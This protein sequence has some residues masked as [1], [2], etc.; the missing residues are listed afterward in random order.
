MRVRLVI[1]LFFVASG[2]V[3]VCPARA[4]EDPAPVAPDPEFA[5]RCGAWRAL[6]IPPGGVPLVARPTPPHSFSSPHFVV[7]YASEAL[8]DYARGVSGFAEHA[9]RILVDTLGHLPP[10][11]DG[12]AGGDERIDVYVRTP[13]ELGGAYG[14]TVP[15]TQVRQPYL[16]SY[17][18]WIEIVDTMTV[19]H[20]GVV[21]AHEVYHVVQLGYDRM[22]SLSLLEM[23]STWFEDRAHDDAN[24]H[25]LF[26]KNFFRRPDR[27][28]FIQNYTNVPWAIFLTE[29]YGDAI[30]AETLRR[31][32]DTPGPNPRGAFDAALQT[33]VGT[34]LVEEFIEFGTWNY[35]TS[36]RDDGAHYS[37]GAVYPA[38]RSQRRSDCY[39][40]PLHVTNHPMHELAANYF[41]FDGDG[42]RGR[43]RIR[44]EPEPAATSYLTVTTFRG[45]AR[46][47]TVT[48][49]DPGASP[50]SFLVDDWEHCD[51]VLAVYQIDRG[52][53][54]NNMVAVSARYEYESAPATPWILVLDR[55]GCRHPYDGEADEFSSRDGEEA[56]L[57]GAL[58]AR[59]E[60]V[61]VTD[62]LVSNLGACRAVFLVGGFGA[63]GVTLSPHELATLAGY[64]NGGG[65]VYLESARLGA[66]V[67]SA[68]AA[69]EPELP[70]FWSMFGSAFQAGEDTLNVASWVTEPAFGAFSFDY[71]RGEPDHRVGILLPTSSDVLARDDRGLVRATV[72][73]V[74]E[75][76]RVV[77]TVLLGA[78]TGRFGSTREGFVAS[79]L[80]LFEGS[81]AAQAPPAR[82]RVV[83]SY[84][85]PVRDTAEL[86]IET[87]NAG[88]A[89]VTVYDVAGRK[90]SS[91]SAR[92]FPGSNTVRVTTPRASGHYFVVVEAGGA[93]AHGRFLVLR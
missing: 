84:P 5:D 17:S 60:T 89:S 22:E 91:T 44:V 41:F 18:S 75:S 33:T 83:A 19:A 81:P 74:G 30:M 11:S 68:L 63:D 12:A 90:V 40:F 86:T 76:T 62:E 59:G 79:V 1:A 70:A 88:T 55:D 82:L 21:T 38:M 72:R 39:P 14:S 28:L 24:W 51:S 10:P 2:L 8:E 67:D 35:F 57:A 34:T 27:G 48:R 37:E 20:C 65:D 85:N 61:V 26:L 31:S 73:R 54:E 56:P 53:P 64:M 87:P 69:G 78:S 7:H 32:A 25:Y 46:E 16:N 6:A 50:D 29:R 23:F 66:W 47:R 3:P 43:L 80:A 42:H 9:Y 49:Y 71:D 77:G 15:D 36:L 4:V 58:V 52:L 45:T 13:F 93:S 92:L